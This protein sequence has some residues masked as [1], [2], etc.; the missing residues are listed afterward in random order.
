MKRT[1]RKRTRPSELL[2]NLFS[3]SVNSVPCPQIHS[4]IRPIRPK[5]ALFL[6]L[7]LLTVICKIAAITALERSETRP[8]KII[9]TNDVAPRVAS[10]VSMGT[11]TNQECRRC[12][13]S[14]LT[15]KSGRLFRQPKLRVLARK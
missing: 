12:T 1:S 6:S 15:E 2:P 11:R 8:R 5:R 9:W 3:A 14:E 13:L 4:F 7:P 10:R